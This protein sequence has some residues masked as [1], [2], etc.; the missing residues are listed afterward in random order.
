MTEQQQYW[1]DKITAWRQSGLSIAAWC[2][3]HDES[4]CRFLY[5]RRQLEP[6]REGRFVELTVQ[7]VGLRLSCSG[8]TLQLERGFDPDLLRDVLAVVK[9]L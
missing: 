9:T 6:Q 2:R 8:I 1:T 3:Q 5:W 4:Y 7:S